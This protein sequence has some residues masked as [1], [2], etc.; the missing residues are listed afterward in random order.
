MSETSST[1]FGIKVK[2][3]KNLS[4]NNCHKNYWELL[5]KSINFITE[6]FVLVGKKLKASL[7]KLWNFAWIRIKINMSH[8]SEYF[9]RVQK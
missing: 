1:I 2:N 6:W 4:K 5:V 7:L 3:C 8:Y 9:S